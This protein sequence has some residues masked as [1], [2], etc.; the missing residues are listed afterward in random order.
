MTTMRGRGFYYPVDSA[1]NSGGR[2]YTV[3]RSAE[4]TTG[5]TIRVTMLNEEGEYF[6]IFGTKG[7]E[8]G[9]FMWPCGIAVDSKNQVY[10]TD[11]YLHRVSIFNE[12]GEFLNKW[13][14]HGTGEGLLDAPSGIAF[15]PEDNVY[16]SDSRNHRIQKFSK[17]GDFIHSF[18]SFGCGDG[19]FNLPWGITLDA[20]NRVYVA[21]WRNDRI[22]QFTEDGEFIQS[23]CETGDLDGQ[24]YR[25]SD[26]AVDGNGMIA[27]ADWG[28]ERVQVLHPDGSLS[29]VLYGES[30]LSKWAIEW[31]DSN[32]DQREA[33]L[34]STQVATKLPKQ[35]QSN[36][37]KASQSESLFWGPVAVVF[38]SNNRLY[39]TEHSRHRLQ[40]FE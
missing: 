11:E 2:I 12:S 35:F 18:G 22:Q 17:N 6:G 36:Y 28:N 38:D 3:S 20:E 32:V 34:N 9:Q 29:Q 24:L 15:D 4:K 37:H 33:R 21:D 8:D 10:V 25:P 7:E 39:V 13:G 23:F 31:L 14:S 5:D 30:T 27:I 26:V 40:I 16:I 1:M 19:E